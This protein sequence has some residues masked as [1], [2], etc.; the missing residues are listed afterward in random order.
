[1]TR[2]IAPLAVPLLTLV[3]AGC[4][5]G[6]GSDPPPRNGSQGGSGTPE[7][8]ATND[9]PFSISLAAVA[10]LQSGQTYTRSTATESGTLQVTPLGS[11]NVPELSSATLQRTELRDVSTLAGTTTT[12]DSVKY[13]TSSPLQ[14]AGTT[15]FGPLSPPVKVSSS[16]AMPATATIGSNVPLYA[17]PATTNGTTTVSESASWRLEA[18]TTPGT[19]WL[20]QAFELRTVEGPRGRTD[21]N[22]YCSR[23][24]PAG[25]LLGFRF[26]HAS[27]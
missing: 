14:Y 21:V 15:L 23:I 4:G 18:D 1:M 20:C 27:I 26:E 10:W 19:A 5:G 7:T 16:T 9:T 22:T 17:V 3:L 11:A 25:T 6:G 13:Y 24:N 8:P 2:W 12:A